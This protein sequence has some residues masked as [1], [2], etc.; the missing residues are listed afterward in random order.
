MFLGSSP[1]AITYSPHIA[2]NLSQPF[3]DIQAIAEHRFTLKRVCDMVQTNSQFTIH[4]HTSFDQ[5]D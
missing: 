2:P 5:F 3:L 4:I 1:V